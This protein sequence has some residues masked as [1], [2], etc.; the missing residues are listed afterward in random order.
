MV[1]KHIGFTLLEVLITITIISI[2]TVV[3]APS[4]IEFIKRDRLVTSSNQLHSIYKLA[5][6]E[7]I[8]RDQSVQLDANKSQWLVKTQVGT[9]QETLTAFTPT[10]HSITVELS[11][12]AISNTGELSNT[13]EYLITD[14][15]T[16]TTDF[17]LCLLQS[18]QSWLV[19]G[20]KTC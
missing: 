16:S 18:G 20:S 17:K 7:A 1:N 15:G 3:T 11:S 4:F 8:K 13:Y 19:E 6:S 5:R 12:I 10:H 9:K 14:D 2:L